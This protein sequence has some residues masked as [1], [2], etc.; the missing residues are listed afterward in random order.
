M[1]SGEIDPRREAAV[2]EL[3]AQAVDPDFA[4]FDL[5]KF[6]G[7][8]AAAERIIGSVATAPLGSAKKV[9]IVDR[10]D[11]LS[12]QDQARVAGFMPK[13]PARS[14][15]IL[16]AD[17]ES[18]AKRRSKQ[19]R[20]E[21]EPFDEDA[22]QRKRKKG[23]QPELVAAVRAH[24]KVVS[25]AKLKSEDLSRLVMGAVRKHGKAIEPSALKALMRSVEASP[26]VIEKEVEKLAVYTADR[27]TIRA[28][29]V[30]EVVCK[31]PEDRIFRM[32]DAV[33]ARRPDLAILLLNETL[34]ASAKPDDEAPRILGMLGKHFRWLYQA[35]FLRSKGVRDPVSVPDELQSM[36]AREHSPLTGVDWQRRKIFQQ[37]D[38]FSLDELRKCSKQVLACELAV[39]GLG[40]GGSPRLNLEMLV[41]RLSQPRQKNRA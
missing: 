40:E 13:L 34:S 15:L 29:D 1:F 8:T 18:S 33:A 7:V 21:R 2:D 20:K 30:N 10:V 14:C 11:R 41:L 24:G 22:E 35:K 26:A 38:L 27:D 31:S 32:I 37:A 19:T 25:F 4:T 5:E 3:V 39:K 17:E 9:V 12:Q 23:L 36:L 28:S 6:D 16:L